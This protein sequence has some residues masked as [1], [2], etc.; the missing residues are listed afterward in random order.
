MGVGVGV[1][2]KDSGASGYTRHRHL[3]PA[4]TSVNAATSVPVLRH[5]GVG[6]PSCRVVLPGTALETQSLRVLNTDNRAG[7]KEVITA[8][9]ISCMCLYL[10]LVSG[11]C[12]EADVLF[13]R[14][15]IV[16]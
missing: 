11:R 16:H 5:Q 12:R 9:T 2:G 4:L 6:V 14:N 10:P 13:L 1:A 3:F 8:T 7:Y 15:N